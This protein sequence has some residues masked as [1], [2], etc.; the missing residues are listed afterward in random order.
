MTEHD[1]Y[2]IVARDLGLR[3][4]QVANTVELLDSGNTVPFIARYRKEATGK[5]TEEE[6]R[7]VEERIRYL[8]NLQER[9]ETILRSIAE[10][11]KLTPELESRINRALKLQEVEDLYLP[12]RPK[13]RTRATQARERG[14]EPLAQII[15]KQEIMSGVPEDIARPFV[16]PEKEVNTPQ[17]ALQGALDI[18]A[19]IISDDADI[20]QTIREFIRRM[21]GWRARR[22]ILRNHRNM[23]C[24]INFACRLKTYCP[25]RFWLLIAERE[26]II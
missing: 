22:K 14:L 13:K 24:I 17:E 4:A 7:A 2:Q 19:E 10:Q 3:A 15:L 5:L 11:G 26:K 9:K 23:I 18:I 12:Y 1:F 21:A 6:I 16:R 25:T 8:R 20:R